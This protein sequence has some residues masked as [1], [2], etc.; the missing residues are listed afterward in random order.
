M[1]ISKNNNH[2]SETFIIPSDVMLE[3]AQTILQADL[4][5][6]IIGVKENKSQIVFNISYQPDLKFHQQ[7][8]KNMKDILKDYHELYSE[9]YIDKNWREG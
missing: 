6:E 2:I 7:A 3:I 1:P 8:I 4:Q 5:H 9:E